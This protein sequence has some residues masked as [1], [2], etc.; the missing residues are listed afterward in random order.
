MIIMNKIFLLNN[1]LAEVIIYIQVETLF[2]RGKGWHENNGQCSHN[3]FFL[4]NDF[5]KLDLLTVK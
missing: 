4:N 5:A 2:Y 1:N 3:F